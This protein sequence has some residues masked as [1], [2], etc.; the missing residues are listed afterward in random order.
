MAEPLRQAY[1]YWQGQP[2]WLSTEPKEA[3]TNKNKQKQTKTIKN[4][5]KTRKSKK[6][7]KRENAKW[8]NLGDKHMT[9]GRINQ[10][11]SAP[12]RTSKIKQKPGK[13]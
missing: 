8:P 11:A 4:K 2:E 10:D 5:I 13:Q 6:Q 12:S 9:T 1:D 7:H 3:K